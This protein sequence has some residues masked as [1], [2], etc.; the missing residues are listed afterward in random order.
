MQ[1]GFSDLSNIFEVLETKTSY[2]IVEEY[3]E[4][5]NLER[6]RMNNGGYFSDSMCA[7]IIEKIL[8]VLISLHEND[9]VHRN[10]CPSSIMFKSTI[11]D[12]YLLKVSG[13]DIF[14]TTIKEDSA[15][16]IEYCPPEIL[17][18]EE[19]DEHLNKVD[20]WALGVLSYAIID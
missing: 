16:S 1:S 19:V 10:I 4:G 11:S 18:N 5:G 14:T 15:S 8:H 2:H 17:I 20:I 12:E 6:K 9:V 3:F 7:K 13:Y